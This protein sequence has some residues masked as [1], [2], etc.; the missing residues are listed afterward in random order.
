MFFFAKSASSNRVALKMVLKQQTIFSQFHNHNQREKQLQR[1]G[2]GSE[3]NTF[4]I[5]TKNIT[6]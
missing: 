1:W 4:Y 2:G 6:E 3:K 5:A